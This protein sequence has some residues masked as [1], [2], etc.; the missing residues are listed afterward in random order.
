MAVLFITKT[1]EIIY[2]SFRRNAASF[3]AFLNH[4]VSTKLTFYS[5]IVLYLGKNE[6]SQY[7]VSTIKV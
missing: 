6:M 2:L 3:T 7:L 5:K 1:R 4:L